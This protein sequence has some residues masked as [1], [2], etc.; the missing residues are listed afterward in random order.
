MNNILYVSLKQIAKISMLLN[1]IIPKATTKVLDSLNV[2][3]ELRNLSFLDGKNIIDNKIIL[4]DLN[5]LFKKVG[6]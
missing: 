3:K 2:K 4:K 5:I 1:P 6:Q